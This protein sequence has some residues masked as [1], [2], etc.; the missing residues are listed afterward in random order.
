MLFWASIQYALDSLS[1]GETSGSPWD[2]P[3]YP[4]K[5]ALAVGI[6][7]LLLQGVG[8]LVKDLRF[9]IGGR[10]SL[11]IELIT[12]LIIVTFI[13]LF[14]VRAAAGV[15]DGGHLCDFRPDPVRSVRDADAGRA[16]LRHDVELHP[17]GGPS[18]RTHG[19]YPP[20]VRGGGVALSRS[21][22]LVGGSEGAASRS[23][24]S[25]PARLWPRWWESSVPK[26]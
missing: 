18:V 12:L 2:P 26:S 24:R 1:V 23:G 3:V 9:A 15:G 17:R 16:R 21:P 13:I 20:A 7:L 25:S 4:F 14:V 10:T 5:I 8:K 11:S 6:L 19:F 22:R